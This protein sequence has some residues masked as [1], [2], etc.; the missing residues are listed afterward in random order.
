M[1]PRSVV[2]ISFATLIL[3]AVIACTTESETP[4]FDTLAV[5][6]TRWASFTPTP[7]PTPWLLEDLLDC[8]TST[9]ARQ[10]RGE[11]TKEL[12]SD[13]EVA[14]TTAQLRTSIAQDSLPPEE[15][16]QVSDMFEN[17]DKI[18]VEIGKLLTDGVLDDTEVRYLCIAIPQW[19]IHPERIREWVENR[20]PAEWQGLTLEAA[21]FERV[22]EE[23]KPRC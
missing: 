11:D 22:A 21:R 5:N 3:V 4:T 14:I 13:C 7:V 16:A 15:K 9:L 17:M 12:L 2:G 18:G 19:E 23:T 6:Q 20:D 10:V 8:D 1:I